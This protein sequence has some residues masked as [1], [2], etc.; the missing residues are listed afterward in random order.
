[1]TNS[2]RTTARRKVVR[3]PAAGFVRFMKATLRPGALDAGPHKIDVCRMDRLDA[4]TLRSIDDAANEHLTY[5]EETPRSAERD[6][7]V[8]ASQLA[9]HW[10]MALTASE[11]SYVYGLCREQVGRKGS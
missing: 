4:D 1:M 6:Q 8:S 7:R 3:Q 2:A 11:R 10:W 5:L 9:C